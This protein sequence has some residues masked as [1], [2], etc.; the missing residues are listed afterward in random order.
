MRIGT[1]PYLNSVPLVKGLECEIYK[2]PPSELVR[3]AKPDDIILAPVVAPFLDPSL[4]MLEGVGIGSFGPVETVKLFFNKPGITIDNL[5]TIS[6][7]T[8]STTSVALLKVLLKYKYQK[9]IQEVSHTSCDAYLMIGDK[10]FEQN[11]PGTFCLDLGQEWTEWTD[12]PFVYACW[13]TQNRAIGEEWKTK[14]VEQAANNLENLEKLAEEIP[15][16]R[17][18]KILKYWRQLRYEVGPPQKKAIAVFQQHWANLEK[19]PVL[20]LNW[21]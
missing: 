19:K 5:K 9:A 8:E 16:G 18:E 6:L 15:Y 4:Y 17:R 14:L 7:D 3:I 1:V 21:I 10:V 12:L 2:A 11:V 13:M 20:P